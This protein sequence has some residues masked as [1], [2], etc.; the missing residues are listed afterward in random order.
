M[1]G[2]GGGY[3]ISRGELE[4]LRREAEERTRRSLLDAEINQMLGEELARINDRDT[5]T[6]GRYLDAIAEALGDRVED[7]ERLQF[8]GSVAKHTYVN[9]LSDVDSLVVLKSA[10]LGELTP[11]ELRNRFARALR[12]RLSAAEVSDVTVGQ[13]AVT[14]HYR[15]GTEIQLLPA[16]HKGD[17]LAIS[18]ADGSS[19][20]TIHPRSFARALTEINRQQRGAVVPAIKLAKSIIEQLPRGA[21]LS[22]YHV[23]ALALGAFKDYDGPRAPRAMVTHFF[24]S[25]SEAVRRPI[26]DTTG[27]SHHIDENL[28]P[29][30]S[31]ARMT[32]SRH[33]ARLRNQ[34]RS[35]SSVADWRELVGS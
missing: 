25:A 1:G 34:M 11:T 2:G 23:E 24:D 12:R 29:P 20:K 8:G 13:L 31:A 33:L 26:K 17:R 16:V 7:F 6:I 15:D 28:G 14:V 4:Q 22:G 27:Q 10:D 18:S 3:S 19:W 35:A 21:Q 5:A 30:D 32:A 9:G